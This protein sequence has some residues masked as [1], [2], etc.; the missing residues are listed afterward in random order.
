MSAFDVRFRESKV[1]LSCCGQ[2][3]LRAESGRSGMN[4][5]RALT[6]AEN[7]G[8]LFTQFHTVQFELIVAAKEAK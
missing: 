6:F 4:L 1:L 8:P 5:K 3:R 2:G 7:S